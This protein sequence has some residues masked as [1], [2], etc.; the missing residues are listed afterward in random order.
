MKNLS[1]TILALCLNL[2]LSNAFAQSKDEMA[3]K[4][5]IEKETDAWFARDAAKMDPFG[6][7][8]PKQRNA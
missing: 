6:Q 7:K 5:V 1:K 3:F 4:N 8:Y 2:L